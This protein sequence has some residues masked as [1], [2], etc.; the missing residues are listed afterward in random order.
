MNPADRPGPSILFERAEQR[1]VA[2]GA[3]EPGSFADL[4]L[5]QVLESLTAGRADYELEPFF[6][7][8]L[9]D[10]GTVRY[11]HDVLRAL[12]QPALL[13]PVRAF[14]REMQ[15]MREHLAQA[16]RLRHP[17]QKQAWFL[18]A[19]TIYCAA[20]RSLRD[21]L[22][23]LDLRSAGFAA[24]HRYL[25]DH[26]T[27]DGFTALAAET[28]ALKGAL[29]E[30]RYSVHIRGNRV[31]VAR[32]EEEEDYS[33]EIQRTFA[34]FEH[35]PARSRRA[36]LPAFV[37]MDHVESRILE[38]VAR[39]HPDLFAGLGDF[40][41]RRG[42]Y[43][44][45]TIRAFDREVQFYLAYLE[46]VSRL[47]SAGLPFCYPEVSS[48]SQDVHA[49]ETF[50]LALAAALTGRGSSVVRND[51]R[52][53]GRERILVVTGPNQGGKTT[54]ARMF[55]QLH[56]LAGLGLPVPGR[57]ARLFLPDRV[58]THFEREEDLATLRGKLDDELVR[59]HGILERASGESVIVM[60]ES[61][62]STTLD[63]ARVIGSA[64][65]RQIVE[66][67][68]L[69]VYV[70]FVDELSRLDE[71]MVSMVSTVV[72]D[73]PARRTYRLVRRP[74]DGLAYAWAIAEKY[75]LSYETLLRRVAR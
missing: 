20:V 46:Y 66:L 52:L 61:F 9:R 43:L 41:A 50:D 22:A 56:H 4:N 69:A 26:T 16:E 29:A 70:T 55:G 13:E 23:G 45:P 12:R 33:A 73:D 37:D 49:V 15:R 18:D 36:K 28:D 53:D 74:A 1:A 40:C 44:D 34:R 75:G 21:A 14:A 30:A 35:G 3:E 24:I 62:G 8:P 59:I 63:D 67:G 65:L 7:A 25:A 68:A 57:E 51:F 72:P 11:R 10:A 42:G 2:D 5:D 48:D 32:Y 64:V 60:N 38:L 19:V 39:L 17:Y 47:E 31:T 6:Y 54:F 58:F 71:A 27:G